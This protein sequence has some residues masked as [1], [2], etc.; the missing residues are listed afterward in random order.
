L[1][2]AVKTTQDRENDGKIGNNRDN[3]QTANKF[4][5]RRHRPC[6][7]ATTAVTAVA[8]IAMAIRIP[9]PWAVLMSQLM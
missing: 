8:L 4:S 2:T 5:S 7:F 1:Q 9:M 6:A 3:T